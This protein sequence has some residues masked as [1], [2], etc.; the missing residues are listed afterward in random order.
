MGRDDVEA[1]QRQAL[2]RQWEQDR[3]Q[4]ALAAKE[5]ERAR[6]EAEFQEWLKRFGT[7]SASQ[8]NFRLHS[9]RA[10]PTTS[11]GIFASLRR[12]EALVH[13]TGAFRRTTPRASS[14][15]PML[16]SHRPKSRG[17]DQNAYYR[18]LDPGTY[19]TRRWPKAPEP[20]KQ[21]SIPT[22]GHFGQLSPRM[23][24]Q[25]LSVTEG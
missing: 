11:G 4:R 19:C 24:A 7:V 14:G 12:T 5:A 8:R 22:V 3:K 10:P 15:L 9:A 25:G 2:E 20:R 6:K 21:Y 16:T 1:Q 23:E 13:G 17:L 18:M